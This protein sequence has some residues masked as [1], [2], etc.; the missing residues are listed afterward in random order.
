MYNFYR[1]FTDC[2]V[3]IQVNDTGQERVYQFGTIEIRRLFKET[4]EVYRNEVLQAGSN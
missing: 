4:I 2:L 3:R 1:L